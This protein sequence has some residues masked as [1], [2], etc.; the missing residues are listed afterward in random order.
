MYYKITN[1]KGSFMY[2]LK[3]IL[4]NLVIGIILPFVWVKIVFSKKSSPMEKV[5]VTKDFIGWIF[6]VIAIYSFVSIINKI[7]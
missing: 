6:I 7:F 1:K 4:F 5:D 3:D 2:Y